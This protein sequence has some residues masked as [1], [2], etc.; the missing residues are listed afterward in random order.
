MPI[1]STS[2]SPWVSWCSTPNPAPLKQAGAL[3][4][5]LDGVHRTEQG[6]DLLSSVQWFLL[7]G[8]VSMF[9]NRA[10]HP[11]SW[12]AER[13]KEVVRG[14]AS[15]HWGFTPHFCFS[16]AY[17]GGELQPH[18]ATIKWP[19]SPPLP[20]GCGAEWSWSSLSLRSNEVMGIS[21]PLWPV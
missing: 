19:A 13:L 9:W 3:I 6:T 10:E 20:G 1:L 16:G 4:C 17:W 2:P 8:P 15:H 18:P 7:Q 14:E 12:A 5:P 21:A 11:P